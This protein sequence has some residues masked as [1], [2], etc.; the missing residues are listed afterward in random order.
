MW[1]SRRRYS[2]WCG[3][4][5]YITVVMSC[6]WVMAQSLVRA[7]IGIQLTSGTATTRAKTQE[8]VRKGDLLRLYV[9]PNDAG[10]IYIVHTDG[11]IA[12]LLHQHR[13][14]EK[15]HK[16]EIIIL[17]DEKSFYHID[18]KSTAE[19]FTVVCS[20]APV[21]EMQALLAGGKLTHSKWLH[22]EK[23][24][25]ERGKIDLTTEVEKPIALAGK[26]RSLESDEF[27]KDLPIYSGK[28]LLVKGYTFTVAQ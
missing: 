8:H 28:S 6:P 18:G 27:I 17:P 22:I 11:A 12:T 4:A 16:G 5:W 13:Q 2:L 25:V 20:T 14:H 10:H 24:L 9:V 7:K 21:P 3:V 23:I 26:T 15:A 1:P 19:R